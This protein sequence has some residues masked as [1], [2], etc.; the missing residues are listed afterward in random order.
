MRRDTKLDD[1]SEGISSARYFL[2]WVALGCAIGAMLISVYGL[3]LVFEAERMAD[4]SF[5]ELQGELYELCVSQG[6]ANDRRACFDD[7][8]GLSSRVRGER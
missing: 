3:Y 6:D 2:W 8:D 7:L 4:R 1:K 5:V